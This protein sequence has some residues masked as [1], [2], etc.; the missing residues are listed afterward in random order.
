M[1]FRHKIQREFVT[2]F[3]YLFMLVTT[4]NCISINYNSK[5]CGQAHSP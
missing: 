1:I 4:E 5:V 2:H 3:I